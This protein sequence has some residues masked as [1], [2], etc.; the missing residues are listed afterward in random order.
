MGEPLIL[1]ILDHRGA[2][3][4]RVRLPRHR[5]T[6][7]RGYDNDVIIDDPYVD[8]RHLELLPDPAGGLAFADLGSANGTWE[9]G[10]AAPTRG[11][12]TRPGLELQIGRT[13]L[14]FVAANQPVPPALPA[15][16]A[17]ATRGALRWVVRTGPAFAIVG[18]AVLAQIGLTYLSST[19]TLTA[20]QLVSPS[21]ALLLAAGLW[22]GGWALANRLVTHRF[23]FLAHLAWTATIGIGSIGLE[24]AGGWLGFFLP[25]AGWLDIAALGGRLVLA[26]ALVAGH[27][28]I[29]TEWTR[30]R[31]W[32]IAALAIAAGYLAALGLGGLEGGASDDTSAHARTLKPISARLVPAAGIEEFFREARELESAVDRLA[33]DHAR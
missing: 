18:A 2:V 9:V 22:A 13:L 19:S 16:G 4:H 6:I 11:G 29:T 21:L 8:P 26:A 30:G 3:R 10:Q 14:R 1:E 15:R 32:R 17:G 20:S 23:R 33:D 12:S 28:W 31:R 7:G 27:L 5:L 24:A 25:G